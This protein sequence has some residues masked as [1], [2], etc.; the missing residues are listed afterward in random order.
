MKAWSTLPE[1]L[2]TSV[3]A[4]LVQVFQTVSCLKFTIRWNIFQS[5]CQ[6]SCFFQKVQ[7]ELALRLP[8]FERAGSPLKSNFG[9]VSTGPTPF[10]K[11]IDTAIRAIQRGGKKKGA[12]CFYM[13]NWH[14]DFPEFLDWKHNAGDDYMRMRTA[15][16]AV[17]MSDEFM[18]RVEQVMIGICLILL[19][20]RTSMSFM[21][22]HFQSV[23]RNTQRWQMQ[24]K[25]RTYK[26][27]PAQEQ[28]RQILVAF[29]RH[30]IHG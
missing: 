7:E 21:A 25:M 22:K 11:I 30:H 4:L 27:V 9:G 23:I 6:M 15:N 2:Q 20:H 3:P 10:A 26:K 28:F 14:L 8:S 18:K 17:F 16:T 24:G 29:R 1:V 5:L 13:E 19:K 12:L